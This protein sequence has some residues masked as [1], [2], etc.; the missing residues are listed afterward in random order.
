METTKKI[1]KS[2]LIFCITFFVILFV[3]QR[4]GLLKKNGELIEI[5]ISSFVSSV[6]FFFISYYYYKRKSNQK[7]IK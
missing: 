6:L 4:L 7:K 3:I 2:T 1:I 5:A